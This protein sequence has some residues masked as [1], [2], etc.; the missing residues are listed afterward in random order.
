MARLAFLG[1]PDVAVLTLEGL[2]NAG[3]EIA[4]VVSQPDVR[5]SRG[6]SL[7]HSP[8]KAAALS[9][10][11][12]VTDD[13][14][15]LN[16]VA[17]DGVIVVAYGKIIPDDLLNKFLMI[18][19]HFSLLPRWRGAAP[20]E[21]ALLAGDPTTG[22][23]VMKIVSELDAG[24]VY[25]RADLEIG[26]KSLEELRSE[27]GVIGTALI[28]DLLEDGLKSLPE[29]TTQT[30]EVVYA[31]KMKKDEFLLDFTQPAAQVLRVI[32]L[33][34]SFTFVENRRLRI[35]SATLVP[36]Y[37]GSPGELAGEVVGT[38]QGGL[39]LERVQGEGGRE[40]D[41][42]AWRRGVRDQGILRLG[43]TQGP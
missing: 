33:G 6:G 30:G 24:P 26:E 37:A 41:A 13:L 43:A 40:M 39:R 19:I 4:L 42:S 20:L 11:L 9:L 22:V 18:N 17:L 3:H 2:H 16:D 27:L 25:A 35:L 12:E 21:R 29:P 36:E 5:R 28:V 38:G 15:K 1:T 34:S 31:A 8:V 32:R 23:C 7:Q 14:E 10:G